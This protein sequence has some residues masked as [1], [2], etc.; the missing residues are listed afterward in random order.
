MTAKHTTQHQNDILSEDPINSIESFIDSIHGATGICQ[1]TREATKKLVEAVESRINN[2]NMQ[3]LDYT[4]EDEIKA[5][6][7]LREI[8]Q[9]RVAAQE[10]LFD[11]QLLIGNF[12]TKRPS[13]TRPIDRDIYKEYTLKCISKDTKK[14]QFI[15]IVKGVR[16][17]SRIIEVGI[18]YEFSNAEIL[19]AFF[20]EQ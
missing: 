20:S 12:E 18:D 16:E 14:V 2:D 19:E 4:R 9:R 17:Y 11:E 1:S 5:L 6:A 8:S 7:V 10:A 3:W 15:G 13:A